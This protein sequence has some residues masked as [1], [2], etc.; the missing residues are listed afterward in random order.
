MLPMKTVLCVS[1]AMLMLMLM[2]VVPGHAAPVAEP[3]TITPF[4]TADRSPLVQIFGMPEPVGSEI[5]PHGEGAAAISL[6][7][8]SNYAHAETASETIL[9]DGEGYRTT[10]ALRYGLGSRFEAGM[11]LPFIGNSGGVFDRFIEGWHDFFGLPQGGRKEAPRNRLDYSYSRDGAQRL[12]LD[13]SGFGIG[14]IRLTAGYQLYKG[15]G[16]SPPSVALRAGLKLPTGNSNRLQGSGSVDGSL[17]L[18]ASDDYTVS[19]GHVTLFGSGGAMAMS[20][21]D[22][23][24]D[25]QRSLAGFGALGVGWAPADWI[26]LILQ[27]S[28]HTPLYEESGLTLLS[29]NSLQ[30]HSGGTLRLPGS[31]LL[32]IA[33]SEDI[34]VD[35][36]PDVTL[37]LALRRRF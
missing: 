17:W 23:L 4:H 16:E 30:L 5:L 15:A 9:L 3:L 36:A 37:H 8:S 35:T 19:I 26:A 22:V 1:V 2:L 32:D 28:G 12:K 6:D 31:F 7:I 25:Q 10:L 34:A 14:D 24:P 27:L 18:D 29:S 33:V 11:E 20:R 13:D 21:G